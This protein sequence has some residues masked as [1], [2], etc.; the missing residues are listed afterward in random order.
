MQS[1]LDTCMRLILG[2]WSFFLLLLS[3]RL[4]WLWSS[5]SSSNKTRFGGTSPLIFYSCVFVF[6]R[7]FDPTGANGYFSASVIS[8]LGYSGGAATITILVL[9]NLYQMEIISKMLK[10]QHNVTLKKRLEH[11]QFSMRGAFRF[12]M[13]MF[14]AIQLA[15]CLVPL[16]YHLIGHGMYVKSVDVGFYIFFLVVCILMWVNL[17]Y[18]TG[19]LLSDLTDYHNKLTHGSR[20]TTENNELASQM[21]GCLE[22]VRNYS[23]IYSS[24]ATE[25]NSESSDTDSKD[26]LAGTLRHLGRFR[27]L[28]V[29]FSI[30]SVVFILFLILSTLSGLDVYAPPTE[31]GVTDYF[32]TI[33]SC[34]LQ[35]LITYLYWQKGGKKGANDR[36]TRSK[37]SNSAIHAPA[38]SSNGCATA[39]TA[40]PSPQN[41]YKSGGDEL[42]LSPMGPNSSSSST[43]RLVSSSSDTPR[44]SDVSLASAGSTAITVQVVAADDSVPSPQLAHDSAMEISDLSGGSQAMRTVNVAKMTGSKSEIKATAKVGIR[45]MEKEPLELAPR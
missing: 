20:K 9:Y 27:A 39:S 17:L 2:I 22:W 3:A 1:L 42:Q 30:I 6:I 41:Q 38:M 24:T 34:M 11:L 35:T 33:A 12:V 43:D 37:S 7:S 40:P 15:V 25:N 28:A 14:A 19:E 13:G 29:V 26:S 32:G 4:V 45:V 36:P 44:G 31:P 21:K 23:C 16:L 8:F 18:V 5:S 10:T